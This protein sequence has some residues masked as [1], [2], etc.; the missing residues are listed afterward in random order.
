MTRKLRRE[1]RSR[2][3]AMKVAAREGAEC[4][5]S[6][7]REYADMGFSSYA[8]ARRLLGIDVGT[9]QRWLSLFGA[10][11]EFRRL[12]EPG[13]QRWNDA[14]ENAAAVRDAKIRNGRLRMITYDGETLHLAEWARRTGIRAR[15]ISRRID[16]YG[17]SV[18]LALT[19][20]AV[21]ANRVAKRPSRKPPSEASRR[22]M[23]EMW[24]RRGSA[25]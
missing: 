7:V 22:R 1:E 10:T 18:Q 24:N 8:T 19:T 15:T 12:G 3:K 2:K 21:G 20:P 9:M 16:V 17:W 6:L 13:H 25:W 4:F 23:E 5:V 11:V 14:G